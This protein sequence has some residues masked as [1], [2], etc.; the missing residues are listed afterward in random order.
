MTNFVCV[1]DSNANS[2]LFTVD[3]FRIAMMSFLFLFHRFDIIHTMKNAFPISVFRQNGMTFS[4]RVKIYREKNKWSS[5]HWWLTCNNRDGLPSLNAQSIPLSVCPESNPSIATLRPMLKWSDSMS[6]WSY[7]FD[8]TNDQRPY[9][10]PTV[11]AFWFLYFAI[12]VPAAVAAAL[13]Y[14]CFRFVSICKKRL[15]QK[16]L[17]EKIDI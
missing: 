6:I 10:G 13:I 12:L 1:C 3:I 5:V 11:E 2:P 16:M 17:S 15:K 7:R 4:S 8:G 9:D 14:F